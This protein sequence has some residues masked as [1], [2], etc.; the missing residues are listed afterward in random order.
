MAV[1]RLPSEPK[2]FAKFTDLRLLLTNGGHGQA[3]LGRRHLE[4]TPTRPPPC[5]RRGE[6]GHG[7]L[8]ERGPLELGQGGIAATVVKASTDVC[9]G[10]FGK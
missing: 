9:A 2:L 6:P 4:R 3:N 7:A 5:S 8:R 10:D 1:Q